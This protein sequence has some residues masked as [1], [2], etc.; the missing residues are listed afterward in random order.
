MN[1]VSNKDNKDNVEEI[2][3][4]QDENIPIL[5]D[6]NNFPVAELD[7]EPKGLAIIENDTLLKVYDEILDNLRSDVKQASELL[8]NFANMVI[9]DGDSSTAS[10]E[11]LV[12]LLKTKIEAT[13]KMTKVADL[14]T[15]IT[16]K[17]PDTYKPYMKKK[18]GYESGPTINIYDNGGLNKRSLM[19]AIQKEKEQE[20]NK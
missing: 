9:N 18:D 13:D 14:M 17:Q 8:D 16:L 19:E 2:V 12:N 4:S 7:D 1:K 5:Q 11:A 3:S 6:V 10:K 15:R 20:G